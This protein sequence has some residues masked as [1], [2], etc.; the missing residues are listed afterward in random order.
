MRNKSKAR[1]QAG[2]LIAVIVLILLLAFV[3]YLIVRGVSS[4][5]RANA[6]STGIPDPMFAEEIETVT[7]P[8]DLIEMDGA[9]ASSDN[10][11]Q[12]DTSVQTPVDQT[13]DELA[14]AANLE[15]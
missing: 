2:R 4:V 11:A 8:P 15:K 1:A 5:L 7:I 9:Y 6:N 3:L 14:N 12:W 10:S 13:A